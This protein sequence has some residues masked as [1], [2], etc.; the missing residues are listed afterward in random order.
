MKLGPKQEADK[1]KFY[2][3]Q[4]RPKKEFSGVTPNILIGSFGYPFVN[5]GALSTEDKSEIDNPKKYAKE[6]TDINKII[7]Q[8]QSLI[9]S[10]L[11][12]PIKR[13]NEKFVEQTQ[14][15]AKTQKVLDTEVELKKAISTNAE[16]H[17]ISMP[18]GPSAEL[19]KLDIT[20]SATINKSVERLTSDTDVKAADALIELQNKHI[21][22]NQLTKLLSTGTLGQ[23]RKLVP[24]KWSITAVDDT[25][26]KNTHNQ[27]LDYPEI[28]YTIMQEELLGN[29]FTIIFIPGTWS[30]ELFE[31]T[32]PNTI[33]N[34]TN[35]II[36]S[37][38]FEYTQGRKKYADETAGGYYATRLAI[39]EYLKSIKKQGQ[40]IVLRIITDRYTAPLG[41]WVVR[42][43]VRKTLEQKNKIY[44]PNSRRELLNKTKELMELHGMKELNKIIAQS[45]LLKEKQT[46]IKKWT[47]FKKWQ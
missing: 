16:F 19:K 43:G 31:M 47:G 15:I 5:V 14:E 36:L 1:S 26:G 45:K 12:L 27:I 38:D 33:H 30:F 18:H 2:N 24:T 46:S 28:D 4:L 44:R 37:H 23:E 41:V 3:K 17:Q 21:D 8:R 35:E 34:N 6:N 25:L 32:L 9:N 11:V 22:E 40:V 10:K 7:A 29:V 13:L 42:E 20:S 39:L